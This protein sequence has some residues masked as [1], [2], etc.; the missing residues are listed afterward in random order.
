[1]TG[2]VTEPP[3]KK[4]ELTPE[5]EILIIRAYYVGYEDGTH[6]VM[7]TVICMMVLTGM[8]A[9]LIDKLGWD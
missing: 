8:L 7:L 4:P 2:G 9:I 3:E 5:D 1:M 6:C